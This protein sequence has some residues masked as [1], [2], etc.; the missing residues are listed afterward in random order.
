MEYGTN[1]TTQ[2][3]QQRCNEISSCLKLPCLQLAHSLVLDTAPF[4]AHR[5]VRDSRRMAKT[6]SKI[7]EH[8]RQCRKE[9]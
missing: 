7:Q 4:S 2:D 6:A 5:Q 3:R 9:A 8:L 1:S